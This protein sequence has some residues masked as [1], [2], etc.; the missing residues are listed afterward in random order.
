MKILVKLLESISLFHCSTFPK[1]MKVVG[2]RVNIILLLKFRTTL[3]V[4]CFYCFEVVLQ[5]I[6]TRKDK[7]LNYDFSSW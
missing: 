6:N 1:E 4:F 5:Y 2:Q 3:E 7:L